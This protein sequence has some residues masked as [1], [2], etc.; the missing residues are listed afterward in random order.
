LAKVCIT[1]SPTTIHAE[2]Y[3]Q[4]RPK[5]QIVVGKSSFRVVANYTSYKH[6]VDKQYSHT[7]ANYNYLRLASPGKIVVLPAGCVVRSSL[8]ERM[9]ISCSALFTSFIL[10]DW[11]GI[12]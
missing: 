4:A 10:P 7:F 3:L 9:V 1:P 2:S 11:M 12:Q 5:I 8:I 6:V